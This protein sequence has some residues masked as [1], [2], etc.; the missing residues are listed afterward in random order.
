[1]ERYFQLSFH[2]LIL[3]AFVALADTGRLDMASIFLFLFFFAWIARRTVMGRGPLLSYRMAFLFS[4]GYILFFVFDAVI[5]S[6]SFISA[7]I[8]LVL[9]LELAKLAQEKKDKDYLYLIILAF[10][11]VL[12]ASSLTIDMSFI[13]MLLLF[14]VALVSTLMS[15]DIY[16]S[17]RQE[18]GARSTRIGGPLGGMSVWATMWI[19]IIGLGL[20]LLIPRIGT[21]YFSRAASQALL[22][23]GFTDTV[24]LGEIG[25]VKLSSA[26]VM[27]TR[28][29]EGMPSAVPKWRGIALDSFDGRR[30]FNTNRGRQR[31][32]SAGRNSFRIKP[33]EGVGERTRFEI[34][35]E[36]LATTTLFG[37]HVIRSVIG[38]FRSL[39]L[40]A[41]DS[42]FKR[43]QSVRR[44]RYE[45]VSEIPSKAPAQELEGAEGLSPEQEALHLQLPQDLD[46]RIVELAETIA[47]GGVTVL[48]RASLLETHLKR[49][50][51][52]S[53]NLTW[54]PG[55]QPLST[56][57]FEARSGH[58]EYFASSMAI[59]L[60]ALGVPTR[61][62]NGFLAGEYNAVGGSYIVRQSDAH[63]WV[64][65]YVPGRG[66]L[67]FDPTPPDPNRGDIGLAVLISHY[68]DAAELFWNSYVL[69]YDSDTQLQLFRSAQ[70][71]VQAAQRSLRRRSDRWVLQ[72]Q[73]A[74]DRLADRVRGIVETRWFWTAVAAAVAFGFAIKHRRTLHTHWK[75]WRLR[76]G[77]GSVDEDVVAQLFYRAAALAGGAARAR[78]PHETWREWLDG[79]PDGGKQSVVSAA[80][81]IFEKVR[82]GGV[83][84]SSQEFS[85]LEET[86]Q[87]LKGR[88]Q[89][90]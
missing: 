23:S 71:R 65:A 47:A 81:E 90:A 83:Q 88:R 17:Q 29:L 4:L 80:L 58:C 44:T 42:V 55:V 89:P 43:T 20:F 36:P 13:L 53:L 11:Q 62:V 32:R 30:W 6:R 34:F 70:E 63:S 16:R 35:L 85:L 72:S 22:V 10:L 40:D 31:R 41:A 76:R 39:E 45:V 25:Q 38:P 18:P 84:I 28:L 68:I 7:I 26:L 15:F 49:E 66:W 86:I 74:S 54:D 79:L 67:E 1:M 2:A 82:Y 59:M 24:E 64:E 56:F 33:L 8:H 57:L 52:Y 51:A 5:L 37:P 77:Q 12:A 61:M 78:L 48:E 21:G 87:Q 60:R 69:T 75:I 27:R 9:F 73:A 46:P 50:Y 14:L 19:V 3:T